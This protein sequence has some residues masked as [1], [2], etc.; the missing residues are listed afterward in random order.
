VARSPFNSFP[1][2][3]SDA[4]ESSEVLSENE[5][6]SGIPK[7]GIGL[8]EDI[9]PTEK[10]PKHRRMRPTRC[11][12][13]KWPPCRWP[14][15]KQGRRRIRPHPNQKAPR[16]KPLPVASLA[17]EKESPERRKAPDPSDEKIDAETVGPEGEEKPGNPKEDGG[18]SAQNS[19]TVDDEK[20]EEPPSHLLNFSPRRMPPRGIENRSSFS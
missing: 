10:Y 16:L 19:S 14:R 20:K 15:K 8:P 6:I 11:Q 18:E 3:E 4:P 12:P 9:P 2:L 17:R 1:A 5:I 7:E 13:T